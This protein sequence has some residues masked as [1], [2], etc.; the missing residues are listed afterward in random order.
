MHNDGDRLIV[1]L[2]SEQW[3]T[4]KRAIQARFLQFFRCD[5]R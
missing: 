2:T 4:K 1:P 3:P 5:R